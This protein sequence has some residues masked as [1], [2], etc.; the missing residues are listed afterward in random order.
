MKKTIFGLYLFVKNNEKPISNHQNGAFCYF[1]NTE[2]TFFGRKNWLFRK[3]DVSLRPSKTKSGDKARRQD[4][5]PDGG[6]G[7]HEGL[8][9]PWPKRPCGFDPR[10]GYQ[11]EQ[12][13]I[14]KQLT[15]S[16]LAISLFLHLPHIFPTS[17][18][19]LAK[20]QLFSPLFPVCQ[21]EF[22]S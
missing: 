3:I 18:I 15:N 9:I 7:R 10:L 8:K 16:S 1:L 6:I 2:L 14:A 20:L 17:A 21:V 5:C 22:A 13:Q 19:F 12:M 4:P 11:K